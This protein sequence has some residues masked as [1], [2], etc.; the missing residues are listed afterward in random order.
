MKQ[1]KQLST[2]LVLLAVML[3]SCGGGATGLDVKFAEGEL[4]WGAANFFG[5]QMPFGATTDVVIDLRHDNYANQCAGL[6]ISSKGRVIWS[7]EQCKIVI[8]GGE[9]NVDSDGEV[10]LENAKNRTLRGAYIHAMRKWFPPSGEAPDTLFFT[11]PQLNTWIE[12][13]YHQNQVEILTYARE[14]L[15]HGIPPGEIGRAHV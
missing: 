14:M 12:L 3:V 4:W 2:L 9:I 6:L 7:G 11:A 8:R 1:M 5:T 13:T 10:I 15:A